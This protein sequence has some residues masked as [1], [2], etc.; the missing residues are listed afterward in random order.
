MDGGRAGETRPPDAPVPPFWG[1]NKMEWLGAVLAR[2]VPYEQ[3]NRMAA[4]T[5]L[6][7]GAV[8]RPTLAQLRRPVAGAQHV[9]MMITMPCT[10]NGA[11]G[12]CDAPGCSGPVPI[13]PFHAITFSCAKGGGVH[14]KESPVQRESEAWRRYELL[15]LTPEEVYR[16]KLYALV[17]LGAAY[18]SISPVTYA[19]DGMS[20]CGIDATGGWR[21]YPRPPLDTPGRAYSA[22]APAA[23]SIVSVAAASAAAALAPLARSC[24]RWRATSEAPAETR[25]ETDAR[26]RAETATRVRAS[27]AAG[28]ILPAPTAGEDPEEVCAEVLDAYHGRHAC[29]PVTVAAADMMAWPELETERA[30]LARVDHEISAVMADELAAVFCADIGMRRAEQQ[31]QQRDSP[32][33]DDDGGG[34][35][36]GGDAPDA[37]IEG[38]E[39][40][41]REKLCLVHGYAVKYRD[42]G[43]RGRRRAPCAIGGPVEYTELAKALRRNGLAVYKAF[44]CCEFAAAAFVFSGLIR[45]EINPRTTL[46]NNVHL[47]LYLSGRTTRAHDVRYEELMRSVSTAH[48]EK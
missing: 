9:E 19:F 18:R 11:A 27:L 36:G 43:N 41:L 10:W 1:T 15:R 26:V 7:T 30:L 38:M 23:S 37:G 48:R 29:G 25:E 35:D 8:E 6:L 44:T 4:A 46:L 13:R 22:A 40:A 5:S 31:Q 39:A 20:V 3:M 12:S 32:D 28:C 42:G 33:D 17:M 2:A 16:V 47:Q 14:A 24:A 21:Y 34:D 45:T